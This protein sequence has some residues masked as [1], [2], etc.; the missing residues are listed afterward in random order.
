[1]SIL[2]AIRR[3]LFRGLDYRVHQP[4]AAGQ[5]LEAYIKQW[6]RWAGIAAPERQPL[7]L[8]V[9]GAG[10]HTAW[11]HALVKDVPS[12]APRIVAVLDAHPDAER[13]FWNCPTQPPEA[14][15]PAQADALLLSSD[16]V[17][18][19]MR[20]QCKKMYG[21]AIPLINLYENLPPGPYPKF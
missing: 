4:V 6:W 7:R 1:M 17:L 8:A 20:T 16:T 9:F 21:D 15:D 10:D 5:L 18:P 2:S 12:P 14:F 11:L 19:H 3:C 13:T